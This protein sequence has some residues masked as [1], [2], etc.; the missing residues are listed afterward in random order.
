MSEIID[1]LVETH[2]IFLGN[3]E[4]D[5]GTLT[6]RSIMNDRSDCITEPSATTEAAFWSEV[7]DNL[8]IKFTLMMRM[9]SFLTLLLV[10]TTSAWGQ[11][12]M[13]PAL[14]DPQ[15]WDISFHHP[16]QHC[17]W[18]IFT[19][20]HKGWFVWLVQ[21]WV[22]RRGLNT[23]VGMWDE[24]RAIAAPGQTSLP[25]FLSP[26]SSLF[27]RL[28]PQTLAAPSDSV[29]SCSTLQM[30]MRVSW[31]QTGATG[32]EAASMLVI[33]PVRPVNAALGHRIAHRSPCKAL[34]PDL[35]SLVAAIIMI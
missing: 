19:G 5:P 1:L 23:D 35:N 30:Q 13:M 21:L 20:E 4:S 17:Y 11:V 7:L 3:Y 31:H 10:S 18:Y 9:I 12:L 33:K 2:E 28:H 6:L 29:S 24:F 25:L 14:D 27:S 16:S 8:F 34:F 26:S 22:L 32:E 15:H